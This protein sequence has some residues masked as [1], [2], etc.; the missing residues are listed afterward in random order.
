M[1][2][3]TDDDIA[4]FRK[5]RARS[6]R[7]TSIPVK[8]NLTE[9]Q[10][11][12]FAVNQY[13]FPG[14]EVKG[15]KRRY[16]P[17]GSA[18]TH[19]IGYV[20]KINDKDVERLNNDGKLANY[21]ATHDIGKLGIERYYEDV[22]HGQTGYEEVEVNNRGRVIRQLKEVPPQ[23]GHDIY[24]TLDLKLQQYIETL[25]A[26]SRA[27]VVV[28]DPRTGGV[29]ALVS[30]L[31][32]TQTCL[33]TVSPAKIIHFVER[34]EYTAGEPAPHRGLSSASTVK[35]YVGFLH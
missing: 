11:A 13:R 17:Y 31:V 20:S 35:P 33:L 7:F 15:Y 6:H 16:Y 2:D 24:L 3:L 34:P 1:V 12:R 23:A 5:E 14:V 4:A 19:V 27:A 26:G 30:R 18:L 32:M 25:L 21:A 9:V 8:T 10:V 28:T 29:L 22:L